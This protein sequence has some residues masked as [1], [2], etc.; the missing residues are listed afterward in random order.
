M[1]RSAPDAAKLRAS[2]WSSKRTG[3]QHAAASASLAL[4]K[5]GETQAL[6]HEGAHAW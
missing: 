1:S 6:E 3:E 4:M 5:D 2:M